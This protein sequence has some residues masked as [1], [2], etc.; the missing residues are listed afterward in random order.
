MRVWFLRVC[1]RG[2]LVYVGSEDIEYVR[3]VPI[4]IARLGV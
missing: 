1:K 2:R 4:R 3:L